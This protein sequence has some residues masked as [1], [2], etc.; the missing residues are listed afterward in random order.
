MS[1]PRIGKRG[2][3]KGKSG[4]KQHDGRLVKTIGTEELRTLSETAQSGK[5]KQKCRNELSKRIAHV[6]FKLVG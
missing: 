5:D 4:H 2:L 3:S 1:G 6:D